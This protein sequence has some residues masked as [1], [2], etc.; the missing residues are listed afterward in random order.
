MGIVCLQCDSWFTLFLCK[1]QKQVAHWGFVGI[2][3]L[4]HVC[5]FRSAEQNLCDDSWYVVCM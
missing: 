3:F 1:I 4:Y 2:L 5:R